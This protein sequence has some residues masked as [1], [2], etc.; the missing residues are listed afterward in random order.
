[1]H[2][3]YIE[4]T[5]SLRLPVFVNPA[6]QHYDVVILGA[7]YTG[8]TTAWQLVQQGKSV[9]VMDAGEVAGGESGLS[10]AQMTELL[11]TRYH[12]LERDFGS[13][14]A[15]AV[16][17]SSRAAISWVKERILEEQIECQAARVPAFLY[18]NT[19]EQDDE[20]DR[21]LAAAENCGVAVHLTKEMP[22]AFK[23]RRALKVDDQLQMHPRLYL[24]G[25]A[26]KLLARGCR[27]FEHSK[28]VKI[29]DGDPC[30]VEFADSTVVESGSVV[31]A[32]HTPICNIV[33]LHTK[34]AAYRTYVIGAALN[35][36]L[37]PAG[38]YFDTDDPYHYTRTDLIQGRDVL[39][40]G[41][42]DH[43]TGD[44]EYTEQRF[45]RLEAFVRGRF[46]IQAIPYRWSGQV[47]ETVDGL[48][49]IGLNSASKHVYVAT[50]FSGNGT[51]F[52]TLAGL[53]ISDLI[54]EQTNPYTDLYQATRIRPLASA[55]T[56][57]SENA[58]AIQHMVKDW[59]G[60]SDAK[61]FEAIPPGEGRVL[62]LHGKKCAVY[63]T[64][65]GGFAAL[66]AVCPHLGCIV[67]WN[68][69]E[70]S[71]DCPC[72]G[73]RFDLAGKVLNGPAMQDLEPVL[74]PHIERVESVGKH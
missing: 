57:V 22:A 11:D 18:S 42:E 26:K 10:T 62:T 74:E 13:A 5:T 30:R 24:Q 21:E 15:A 16:A 66:S 40:V 1:M 17:R 39:I 41:G 3:A 58:N 72:H 19:A 27:I 14:S 54:L 28:A 35:G 52:G 43:K 53:I 71:W 55:A 8:L 44:A 73:S 68:G 46:P 56:F 7:G 45:E 37:P 65:Q 20:I 63:R 36:A 25:L 34:L 23:A 48:P 49:Y 32:T 12:E 47:I 64:A 9:A 31:V 33:L 61:S 69:A 67:H 70:N 6:K 2:P 51:T 60:G 59:L 4:S 50:G 38:M 29:S